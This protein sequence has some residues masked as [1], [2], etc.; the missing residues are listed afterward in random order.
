MDEF[1]HASKAGFARPDVWN[2]EIPFDNA[3]AQHSTLTQNWVDAILDG[4][5]LVAPGA[6]G[7]GSV[8]LANSILFSSLLGQTVELPMDAAAYERKLNQLIQE[9]R[10]EK[11]TKEITGEDFTKSF[12]R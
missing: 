9:S 12:V 11:K 4:S 1:S 3:P 2:V 10:F 6:Q 5:S 8:E 7:I